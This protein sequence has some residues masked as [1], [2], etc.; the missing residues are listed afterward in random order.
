[1]ELHF[2]KYKKL[3]SYSAHTLGKLEC[4]GKEEVTKEKMPINCEELSLIGHSLNG[5]YAVKGTEKRE[6]EMVYCD[7]NLAPNT[8][9]RPFSIDRFFFKCL[10]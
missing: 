4:I 7:F 1:M 2:G 6:I 5:F 9:G 10:T 3:N 8:E